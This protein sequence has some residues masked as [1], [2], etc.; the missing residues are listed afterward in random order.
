ML[1]LESELMAEGSAGAEVRLLLVEISSVALLERLFLSFAKCS[2]WSMELR[3]FSS[4]T[5]ETDLLLIVLAVLRCG[6]NESFPSF[7]ASIL[8]VKI[9]LCDLG[10]AS[11]PSFFIAPLHAL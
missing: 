3:D 5:L 4:S 6:G 9:L 8:S 2:L 1:E 7:L 11:I 10:I